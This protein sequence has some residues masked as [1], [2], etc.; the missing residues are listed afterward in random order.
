MKRL[1]CWENIA[2]IETFGECFDQFY[3]HLRT[4]GDSSEIGQSTVSVRVRMMGL[5]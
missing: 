5:S 2:I 4:R 3:S 1:T